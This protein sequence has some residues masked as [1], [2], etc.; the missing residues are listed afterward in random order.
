MATALSLFA[1]VGFGVACERMNIVELGVENDMDVLA[2]R[3]AAGMTTIAH[4]VWSLAGPEVRLVYDLLLAGPPCQTF[5]KVG[6][7]H[8]RKDLELIAELARGLASVGPSADFLRRST[9]HIEDPRTALVLL[10]LVYALRDLP[11]AIVLEQ[12]PDVLPIWEA[13]AD[14][15]KAY[16]YSVVTQVVAAEQYGVPQ[17]RRRAVLIANRDRHVVMPAPTHS[18]YHVRAPGRMDPGVKPWVSMADAMGWPE[19]VVG[20]PRLADGRDEGVEIGDTEYRSRDL[21]PTD[22]PAWGVTGKARSWKRWGF[23]NRPA[24]VVTGHGYATRHPSGVQRAH[25][26]AIE[27]GTFELREP[28]TVSSAR[29]P[30]YDNVSL[31]R[32]YAGN[33]VNITPEEGALLQTFDPEFPFIGTKTKVWQ[34]IGNAIPPMLAQHLIGAVL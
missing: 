2:M 16:G 21:R 11:K 4:D 1:G 33:A 18:R 13:Y 29:L 8:G 3:R 22:R 20:F 23:V 9:E 17:T 15:L 28:W 7:G 24:T 12:V 27:A 6:R 26:N 31:S 25:L 19:G 10:P 30:T 14:T 5:S 32:S 34:T